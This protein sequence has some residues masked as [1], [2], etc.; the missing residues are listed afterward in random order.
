MAPQDKPKIRE[1]KRHLKTYVSD[2]K[3]SDV[4]ID[5]INFPSICMK[6]KNPESAGPLNDVHHHS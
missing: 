4:Y 3:T 1:N 2:T 5:N 6:T